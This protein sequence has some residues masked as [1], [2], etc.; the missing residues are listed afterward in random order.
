MAVR[1]GLLFPEDVS[2]VTAAAGPWEGGQTLPPEATRWGIRLGQLL[3]SGRLTEAA[4]CELASELGS[5]AMRGALPLDG[6]PSSTAMFVLTSEVAAPP[7]RTD[8]TAVVPLPPLPINPSLLHWDRYEIQSMLGQGGMGVVYRARDRVLDRTVAIKF[9][10]GGDPELKMRFIHEARAQA[11]ID[12]PNV[13]K[14][15]EV[16]E[17]EGHAYISMQLVTGPS[18]A[19]AA[20]D[21][22]LPEKIG[23][24]KD[25]AEAM[26]EAHRLG[27]I[28]RDIK[29]SNIIIERD[30]DRDGLLC[31]VVTDFGLARGIGED[32]G[33]TL[34]GVVI[35]T[36]SYMAPEQ[37]QGENR[38]LDRRTDVYS[39]GATLY[40]LL[41]GRPP[42]ERDA[43][44]A[45][46][47]DVV[48]KEPAPPRTLVPDI[49]V[50]LETIVLKCLN[51]EP[52]Q[53]YDSA[54]A[55]AEDLGRYIDGEPVL[56]RRQGRLE[57]LWRRAR[58]HRAWATV[59]AISLACALAFGLFALRTFLDAR[60]TRAEAE[61]G[62]RL[63]AELGQDITQIEWF[64]RAA[65]E[66]PLHDTTPEQ[67]LIRARMNGMAE[68]RHALGAWS[69]GPVYYALGRGHF[70]LH[71]LD[72][73]LENLE[74]A[75]ARG[76][77][78]RELH[79]TR[80]RVL[81]ELYARAF[82]EARYGGDPAWRE[83]RRQELEK[84][85]LAPALD[86]LERSRGLQLESPHLLEAFIAFY[87][88]QY[89]LAEAKAAQ[90][91]AETPWAYEARTLV[92]DVQ[93]EQAH[94][95][96]DRGAYEPAR[97]G[98][99][100]ALRRYQ[101]ASEIGRS[102]PRIYVAMAEVHLGMADLD[103]R[104]GR[105]Q[106]DAL[107]R[108]LLACEQALRADPAHPEGHVKKALALLRYVQDPQAVEAAG[109][110]PGPWIDRLLDVAQRAVAVAPQGA[111]A[112][113][114]LGNAYFSRGFEEWRHGKSP[115][116][117]WDLALAELR[118]A[119][120]LEPDFP[121][122]LN[123]LGAVHRGRGA[124][125]L[126]HGQDPRPDYT[127]AI[128]NYRRALQADAQYLYA[129]TNLVDVH[130]EVADY[131]VA[132]GRDPEAEMRQAAQDGKTCLAIDGNFYSVFNSMVRAE[133]LYAQYLVESGHNPETV[134]AQ[135]LT[136]LDRAHCINPRD[137]RSSL[138]FGVAHQLE[139]QHAVQAG[140][141]PGAALAKGWRAIAEAHRLQ[142][143]CVDC[144]IVGTRLNLVAA[145]W[146]RKTGRSGLPFLEEALGAARRAVGL[147]PDLAEALQELAEA[148]A[149][150]SEERQPRPNPADLAEG[151]KQV[152]RALASNPVL[153]RS[154]AIRA[155]LLRMR[156]AMTA[157]PARRVAAAEAR[158][159]LDRALEL[160]RLLEGPY[161]G[162]RSRIQAL[163]MTSGDAPP[164]P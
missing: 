120:A 31:P 48:N 103:G 141:D 112:H 44:L 87:R 25:V 7:P 163:L 128:K 88:K 57:R 146:A 23:I 4:L 42:F 124:Y 137:E 24:M 99:A 154:H 47:L 96:L 90:A 135:A 22:S 114:V 34:T 53:R 37:A 115:E 56:G 33:L 109:K 9:L 155:H 81:G 145:A 101:E 148:Y 8:I 119:T 64:L 78:S 83:R 80:G 41:V 117:F 95:D 98:F 157:P 49:P 17:I 45:L 15:Y 132:Y 126:T 116:P 32:R 40:E 153:A 140:E 86:E 39:L 2:V 30:L 69:E 106:K 70:I 82:K 77:D 91:T 19:D 1:R 74:R 5:M 59:S 11:R 100:E 122:A 65:E 84:K 38:K 20:P 54:K 110:D 12:H 138:L 36:P 160:N 68:R 61:R 127:E 3:A 71:E 131:E 139:A 72:G 43:T 151:L 158:H 58:K 161:R 89:P 29:P 136:H 76:V 129:C 125:R 60:R 159:A 104:Q 75:A 50:D 97:K 94:A 66:L 164:A 149:Q 6:P 142:E 85:Y 93:L 27:I 107:D 67:R 143:G 51:K 123:D 130:A 63:A 156:A 108:A 35:G 92:G 13:C 150:L 113:D 162:E 144:F 147:A 28:H 55:L 152:E 79:Y 52:G 133:L 46:L 18:L 62:A 105:P 16:G 102:D 21:L 121:W 111:E 26:H 73:A 14:V 10:H 134:L 118:K